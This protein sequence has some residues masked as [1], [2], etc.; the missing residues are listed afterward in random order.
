[1]DLAG[2]VVNPIVG[3]GR[4]YRR[5]SFSPKA[6]GFTGQPLSGRRCGSQDANS[7]PE[8]DGFPIP[9]HVAAQEP[10]SVIVPVDPTKVFGYGCPSI[11]QT[12][13]NKV[14]HKTRPE[15]W[16]DMWDMMNGFRWDSGSVGYEVVDTGIYGETRWMEQWAF[17]RSKYREMEDVVDGV[18][19]I[20]TPDTKPSW[21]GAAV[22][23]IW[24]ARRV[25]A[26]QVTCLG[27]SELE[28][29]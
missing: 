10:S 8:S 20:Q 15:W 29:I 22:A 21:V 17:I 13:P 24:S 18:T 27:I 4:A 26:S 16:S 23:V 25:T 6:H 5:D 12:E 19:V 3:L 2:R 11:S 28:W 14:V 7:E 9:E 1:L